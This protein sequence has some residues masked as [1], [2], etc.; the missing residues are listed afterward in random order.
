MSYGTSI[1]SYVYNLAITADVLSGI[2]RGQ[3]LRLGTTV[4]SAPSQL[5]IETQLV[6][7]QLFRECFKSK[8]PPGTG[9]IGTTDTP[10]TRSLNQYGNSDPEGVFPLINHC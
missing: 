1:H 10:H 9:R 5:E 4:N 6:M 3:G 7:D 8:S 2:S